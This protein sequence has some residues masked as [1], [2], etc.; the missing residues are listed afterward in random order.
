M[1]HFKDLSY[2][3]STEYIDFPAIKIILKTTL[4]QE[5]TFSRIKE[6][7]FYSIYHA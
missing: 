2:H 4:I 1:E 6:N 5:P 7:S 3:I